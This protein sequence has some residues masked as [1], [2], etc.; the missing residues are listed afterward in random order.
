MSLG[1]KILVRVILSIIVIVAVILTV[2]ISSTSNLIDEL[3]VEQAEEANATVVTMLESYREQVALRAE[4]IAKFDDVREAIAAGGGP[5]LT[6]ALL[7]HS[8]GLDYITVSDAQGIV[9]ARSHSDQR[10]DD[11]TNQRVVAEAIQTGVGLTAIEPG[12][13]I[14]LSVRASAVIKDEAGNT[15]AIL[16]CGFDLSLPEHVDSIKEQS[17]C[18]VTIFTGDE[19]MSTTLVDET[20]ERVTGTKASDEVIKAV[21]ENH[22]SYTG[23]VELFGTSYEVAYSPIME[24]DDAIGMIFAGIDIESALA[25]QSSMLRLTII[26]SVLI[27]AIALVV[28]FEAVNRIISKPLRRFAQMSGRLA[29]GDLTT[30]DEGRLT[31]RKDEI[32]GL[33]KSF[34]RVTETLKHLQDEIETIKKSALAGKL[35]E[36]AQDN[37]EVQGAYREIVHSINQVI[38]VLV[39][40]INLLP[41]PIAFSDKDYNVLFVNQAGA[42]MTGLSLEQLQG[43]KCYDCLRTNGCNTDSCPGRKAIAFGSPAVAELSAGPAEIRMYSIPF[44]DDS[45]EMAGFIEIAIDET[46]VKLASRESERQ[47]EAVA[48][49]MAITQKQS[50]YQKMGV[51]VMIQSI[52]RLARG[53]LDLQVSEMPHDEDTKEIWASFSELDK[54][55]AESCANIKGYISELSSVLEKISE[56]NLNV[57]IT[58]EYL[59]DF[60]ALKSSINAIADALNAVFGEIA[61]AAYQ[62]QGGSQ[63]VAHSAQTLA[64]GAS[65][66]AGSIEEI[67][68]TIAEVAEQTK[69][70]AQNAERANEI[71]LGA[72]TDAEMGS[73][74]MDEMVNAMEAIKEASKGIAG[75]IKTIEDI[76]F[77]TNILAL[78]AAVEAARAGEHGKGFAVVAEEVRTLAARSAAAAK[79]TTEMIDNSLAKVEAGSKISGETAAALG[80]IV[81][82]VTD[83]VNIVA[84]IAE[85]SEKQAESIAQIESGVEQISNV[86]QSNTATAEESAS[87]SQ[88]MAGQAQVLETMIAEFELRGQKSGGLKAKKQLAPPKAASKKQSKDV[89]T[90]HD[91]INDGFEDGF[92]KY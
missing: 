82:G 23:R 6:E 50:E 81:S 73:R 46:Q 32:G 38:D 5:G 72:K 9:M 92:G 4:E 74:Q 2:V 36:R 75:I 37:E 85:A 54:T 45:G 13:Q 17:D 78:N 62:V 21:L 90:M 42:A 16:I 51:Q 41:L 67:S 43:K 88:Q 91:E 57:G 53:D 60:A 10:G 33:A 87:A 14:P 22:G 28:I 52:Q 7:S 39:G 40:H 26:T 31:R 66:Q 29:A 1:L 8:R 3:L 83:T 89:E 18:E 71:S 11:I 86:T 30:Q 47:A 25:K 65:E 63:Q 48:A 49:Q 24:S 76:A 35:T 19:R 64:Q 68:A 27:A 79:E 44:K 34:A 12:A 15:A 20:G 77:Q 61:S 84:T 55:L 69:N 70:N 58:R 59:G 80:K 56:K